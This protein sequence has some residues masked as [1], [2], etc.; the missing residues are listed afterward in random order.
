MVDIGESYVPTVRKAE[1]SKLH[2]VRLRLALQPVFWISILLTG[3]VVGVRSLVH[4]CLIGSMVITIIKAR[5]PRLCVVK[6]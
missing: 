4:V 5:S 3:M 2:I 1:L 6:D